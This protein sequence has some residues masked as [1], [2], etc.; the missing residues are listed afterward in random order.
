MFSSEQLMRSTLTLFDVD[1]SK[2]P[3][4]KI[5]KAQIAKGEDILKVL[6]DYITQPADI[7]AKTLTDFGCDDP[8]TYINSRISTL[9]SEFWTL[10]PYA[11]SRLKPP[12]RLLLRA[13]VQMCRVT[14]GHW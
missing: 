11:S 3:V 10:I 12:P 4:G 6:R 8:K 13:I 14:R 9:S 2:F 5:S 1:I 7:T